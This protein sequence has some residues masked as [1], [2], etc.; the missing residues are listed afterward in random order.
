MVGPMAGREG[1]GKREQR[2]ADRL[3]RLRQLG[4]HHG[5]RHGDQD[6][7]GKAL[8]AAHRDHR[9]E[10]VGE[11]AGDGEQREQDRV[12]EDVAAEREHLA[13]V[14]GQRDHDDLADEVGGRDPGAVVDAGADA[15][16]D[17]EQRGV[18]DLD[19]EDR[20]EGA[21]HAGEHGD[22]RGEARLVRLPAGTPRGGA[23]R[24]ELVER[25]RGGDVRHGRAS[26]DAAA[27]SR[28]GRGAAAV[29]TACGLG[30]DG[31]LDRHAGPQLAG[32]AAR[33]IEHDLHRDALHDLGE[34]AGGVVGR[35]QREL[36]AARR[37]DAVD[38]AVEG[39][40]RDTCRPR[41]RPRW[42]G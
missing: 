21:D 33:R 42:P 29:R 8:Q 40:R 17:V 36:L 38:V 15:A 2:E 31:R 23:R 41:S 7:A 3:L 5:E 13:E 19:V 6:A 10:V 34:V 4:Q 35:Q 39:R 20:H 25:Q 27:V 12:A 22:P 30:V 37:R 32:E 11:G 1:H 24:R 28:A 14:V 26:S 9:A 18:G 16:L